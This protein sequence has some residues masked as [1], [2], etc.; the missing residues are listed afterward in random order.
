MRI[1]LLAAFLGLATSSG[2]LAQ[3]VAEP[4]GSVPLW[5]VI[6]AGDDGMIVMSFPDDEANKSENYSKR[7]G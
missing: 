5:V 1:V 2:V 6:V 7:S 4:P 3:D